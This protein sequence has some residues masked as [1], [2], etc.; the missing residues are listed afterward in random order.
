MYLQRPIKLVFFGWLLL[1]FVTLWSQETETKKS[2]PYRSEYNPWFEFNVFKRG[3][4][5]EPVALVLDSLEAKPRSRWTRNDSLR[6][7]QASLKTG[8]I[9]LSAYYFHSLDVDYE[10]EEEF[11]W[12]HIVVHFL[13]REY[14]TCIQEIKLAEP[15]VIEFSKLYFF[16]KICQAKLRSLREEN[17]YEKESVLSWEIDSSIMLL[18]KDSPEFHEKVIAP[19]ENLR[20]VLEALIRHIHS[21]DE[22]IART[23]LEMGWIIEAYISPTQA[24]IAMSLA[25][26]YDKWDKEITANIKDVKA[27]IIE[28]RYRIPIF[29]KYFPR[30]EYWRFDYNVLKEQVIYE[31]ND[32]V[33]RTKPILIREVEEKELQFKPE[34]VILIGL[35]V[36][37]LCILLFVKTRKK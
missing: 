35:G 29:R 30:I 16:K 31:R 23:C 26:Q 19:L 36:I 37:F 24:F 11:W 17:W 15:G 33:V 18:D 13:N 21:N 6:F 34:L 20:F 9:E 7:A 12:D 8:N 32:T 28:K 14:N 2:S 4:K 5:N 25:R 3:Y 10:K 1:S 22:V 27:V